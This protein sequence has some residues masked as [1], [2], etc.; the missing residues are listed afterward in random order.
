MDS[1]NRRIPGL[2]TRNGR[3]YAQL[4][5]ERSDG[6][7]SPRRFPLTVDGRPVEGIAE[8]KTAMEVLRHQRR[9]DKLPAE[10]RKPSFEEFAD[11]YLESGETLQKKKRT[12]HFHRLSIGRWKAHIGAVRIDKITPAHAA[13]F[14]NKRLKGEG[15]VKKRS[16]ST[17]PRTVNTDLMVLR[18]ILAAAK[19]AG[20][21]RETPVIPLM[22]EPPPKR[23]T[24]ISTA[25]FNALLAACQTADLK[26]GQQLSDYLQFLAYSGA[27]E[28]EAL[29]VA[30]DDVDIENGTMAIG[31][32]GTAKNRETRT[33]DLNPDLLDLLKQMETRRQPDSRWLFPSPQRGKHDRRTKTFRETFKRVRDAAKLPHVGFHH[34]RVMFISRAVMAGVDYL[35]IASWVGHKDG[36]VLIGRV[37]GRL[38]DDH[39][40]KMAARLRLNGGGEE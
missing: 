14:K 32:G 40:R 3:F 7:K 5:I 36:G 31:S 24:L 12:V 23:R 38:R 18:R 22:D 8:A 28:Q 19:E 37:Y 26:N 35:T 20:H 21:L 2:S 33:I 13:S 16:T 30:W 34:L 27:R 10:G 6:R 39:R 9:E 4:W 1:R 15:T 11:A 17:G 29:C 25:D